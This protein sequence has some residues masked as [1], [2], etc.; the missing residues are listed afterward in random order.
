M[1]LSVRERKLASNV[2]LFALYFIFPLVADINPSF[3]QKQR[4]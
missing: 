4:Y 2:D 3:A 1:N